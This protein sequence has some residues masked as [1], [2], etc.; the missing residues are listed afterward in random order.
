MKPQF[1]PGPWTVNHRGD[2]VKGS[3]G[4][5]ETI[6]HVTKIENARLISFCPEMYF[7]L[8]Q[9]HSWLIS[10]AMP[11]KFS[12]ELRERIKFLLNEVSRS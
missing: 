9:A 4:S 1:T 11:N 3:D 7:E 6:A 12:I 8:G 10:H 2:V 5:T